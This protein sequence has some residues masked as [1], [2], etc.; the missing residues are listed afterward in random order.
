M[1]SG[2]AAAVCGAGVVD[3][4]I[5]GESDAAARQ[6]GERNAA[7]TSRRTAAIGGEA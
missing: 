5:A 6:A 1:A 7:C 4:A 2:E 3:C